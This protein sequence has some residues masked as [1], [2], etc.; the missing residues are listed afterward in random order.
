MQIA[1]FQLIDILC[2]GMSA[3]LV[4]PLADWDKGIPTFH[5]ICSLYMY[6]GHSLLYYYY[7][8][9]LPYPVMKSG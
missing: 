6:M 7:Y 2:P 8:T 1:L 9:S 5:F 3:G 4:D